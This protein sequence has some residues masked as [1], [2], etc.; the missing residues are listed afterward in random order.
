MTAREVEV[1]KVQTEAKA[2]EERLEQ[3]VEEKV[4]SLAIKNGDLRQRSMKGNL[5]TSSPKSDITD[6]LIKGSIKMEFDVAK[7]TRVIKEKTGVE[8]LPEEVAAC[9][10][11]AGP[12]GSPPPG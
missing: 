5:I 8:F 1:K 4:E 12:P 3:K 2:K 6:T 7:V 9:D 11:W 10:P